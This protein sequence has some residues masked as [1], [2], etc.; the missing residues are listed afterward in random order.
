[1]DRIDL[2]PFCAGEDATRGYLMHPFRWGDFT[3][4]IDGH[5]CVRVPAMESDPP[6]TTDCV[7][8][9]KLDELLSMH[10]SPEFAPLRVKLPD[11]EINVCAQCGGVGEYECPHCGH[12]GECEKCEGKGMIEVET[13]VS[14]GG[15][16]FRAQYIRK[17]AAL[18][19]VEI[20]TNPIPI[21]QKNN[22]GIY[23]PVAMPFRFE[24]G[25]GCV[26]PILWEGKLDLGDIWKWR[27]P[28]GT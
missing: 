28:D 8:Q 17:I 25:I 7:S 4:A 20:P 21:S 2:Q 6:A 24:G 15:V 27:I 22:K 9:K 11:Q 16:H 5:I 1:M 19:N 26:M 14:I 3:Y 12:D 18:P 13:S 10:P 23:D